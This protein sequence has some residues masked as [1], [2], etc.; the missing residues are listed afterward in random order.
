MRPINPLFSLAGVATAA[1]LFAAACSSAAATPQASVL[2]ATDVPS[3][4]PAASQAATTFTIGVVNDATLGAYLTGQNGMTLYIF[5]AD[6]PGVSNCSGTCATNWPPATLADGMTVTPPAGATGAFVPIIRADGTRQLAHDNQ[7]L[8]YY[9]GDSKP[10]DTTGQ[11]LNGKWFV[12]P[13]TSGGAAASPAA[14]AATG[15]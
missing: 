13:L 1:L 8:Y 3:T 10:G 6:A 11:G 12:A 5:T 7:P 4:A 9:A 15:Y 14:S 2:V